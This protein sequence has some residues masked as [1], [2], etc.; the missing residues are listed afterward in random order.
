MSDTAL[1]AALYLE[2]V[3]PV[4]P[5]L[6]AHDTP[7][8]NALAG[9]DV[10]VAFSFPGGPTASLS[11]VDDRPTYSPEIRPG[12]VRLWFPTAGQ[13]VRAFDGSGRTALA[14]PLGGFTRLGRARRLTAAGRRLEALLN[15]RSPDHLAL[16]AWSNLAV[17]IHAAITWLRRHPDGPA[18][19]A[20]LGHGTAVFSCPSFPAPL[21]LDLG[22]LTTGTGEPATPVMVRITFADLA[23]VLAELDH[24]LDATAA[25]G[26]GTLK[27]CGYLPLAENLSL[28]MLN[29][30][31]LLKPS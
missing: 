7:L 11:V 25:L 2:A 23:T 6:A 30:G 10:A 4:M 29:A 21:W 28:V 14:V 13:L 20:Q 22:T 15:T 8:A 5:L 3:L 24:Q 16:H 1:K 18:T 9:S 19:H 12:S 27:I 26:F 17:G 31:K